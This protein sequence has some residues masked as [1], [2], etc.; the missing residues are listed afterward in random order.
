MPG[1]SEGRLRVLY[2]AALRERLGR[3][4]EMVDWPA[5]GG[6]VA[7]LCR[8]LAARHGDLAA[9]FTA[10]ELKV[11]VNQHYAA[12]DTPVRPGDEVALFPPVT[13]G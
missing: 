4:E 7:Q 8:Q 5:S 6:T 10:A 11:A 12:P 9:L 13:G 1:K 3:A 2:F